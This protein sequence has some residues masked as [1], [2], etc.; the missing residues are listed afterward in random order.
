ML[1]KSASFLGFISAQWKFIKPHIA[2]LLGSKRCWAGSVDRHVY[3]CHS[4]VAKCVHSYM[5]VPGEKVVQRREKQC[6][7]VGVRGRVHR[8]YRAA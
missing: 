1:Q 7:W 5:C 3:E 4:T 2:L 8:G 6:A